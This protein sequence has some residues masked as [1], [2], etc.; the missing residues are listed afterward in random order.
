MRSEFLPDNAKPSERHNISDYGDG[1]IGAD[2]TIFRNG[3]KRC[4]YGSD[5]AGFRR[6]DARNDFG[7]R[8]VYGAGKRAQSSDSDSECDGTSGR[9]EECNGDGDCC[10]GK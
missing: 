4:E 10:S 7:K 1:N 8:F 2:T 6:C 3:H 5:L 9:H